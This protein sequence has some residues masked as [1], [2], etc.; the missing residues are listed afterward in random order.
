MAEEFDTYA[1]RMDEARRMVDWCGCL[2]GVRYFFRYDWHEGTFRTTET[3]L[4][5]ADLA[6]ARD[7]A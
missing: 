6:W 4:S 5:D 7:D 3:D 1:A 2:T